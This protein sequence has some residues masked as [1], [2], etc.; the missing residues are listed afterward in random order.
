VPPIAYKLRSLSELPS[1]DISDW[2]ITTQGVL[3][4]DHISPCP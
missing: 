1:I 3:V 2:D 4:S